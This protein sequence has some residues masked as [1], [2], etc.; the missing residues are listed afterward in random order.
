[1]RVKLII[2]YDG[3]QYYGWQIQPESKTIQNEIENA[4]KKIYSEKISLEGA[5]RTDR[6]VH[7]LGQVATCSVPKKLS[8]EDLK[9]AINGNIPKDIRIKKCENVNEKFHARFSARIRIYQYRI[10]NKESVFFRNYFYQVRDKLDVNRMKEVNKYMVGKK[11]FSNLS[12]KDSGECYIKF[13]G[14]KKTKDI[15]TISLA[16][17]RFLRRMVRGIAGFYI[18]VG[19]GSFLPSSL[20][21]VL[22]GRVKRPV[23]LPPQGLYLL[24]V[25]Y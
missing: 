8:S 7:A 25:L 21:D 9:R 11:D 18:M 2:E 6:G 10:Y 22:E 4:L 20:N 12:T 23:T 16:A 5:G 19:K 24:K 15:I 3:S 13:A 17:N 1:M 14:V